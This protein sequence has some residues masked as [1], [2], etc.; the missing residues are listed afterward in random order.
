MS[1]GLS[2]ILKEGYYADLKSNSTW[3]LAGAE[4]FKRV[5]EPLGYVKESS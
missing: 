2:E 1:K 4:S 5:I 3:D